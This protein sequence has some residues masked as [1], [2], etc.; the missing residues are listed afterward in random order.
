M[1]RF[2]AAYVAVLFVAAW[3]P[4]AE[5]TITLVDLSPA[6]RAELERN[7]YGQF[8]VTLPSLGET[9]SR[10][11]AELKSLFAPPLVAPPSVVDPLRLYWTSPGAFQFTG[12]SG[13]NC[14]AI[15]R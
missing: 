14:G 8:A 12:C 10:V 9:Q 2:I 7:G 6:K 5:V 15:R 11:A 4:A 1:K 13:G 3:L